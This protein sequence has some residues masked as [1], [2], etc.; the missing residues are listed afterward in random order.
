MFFLEAAIGSAI[1]CVAIQIICANENGFRERLMFM[2]GAEL[3]FKHGP[4]A[5]CTFSS[6]GLEERA[7]DRELDGRVERHV[8]A[9]GQRVEMRQ[10]PEAAAGTGRRAG[11]RRQEAQEGGRRER[12][13]EGGRGGRQEGD[14]M[15]EVGAEACLLPWLCA[16]A[17][18]TCPSTAEPVRA[19]RQSNSQSHKQHTD[20]KF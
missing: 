2:V 7:Q 15:E 9:R 4:S 11:G 6:S 3:Q 5:D 14:R 16:V 8:C 1:S 20:S 19:T 10:A 17:L 13:H 12:R 18:F